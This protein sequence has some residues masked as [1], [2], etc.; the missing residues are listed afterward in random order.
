M[1]SLHFVLLSLV[2]APLCVF[3]T[4][5]PSTSKVIIAVNTEAGVGYFVDSV[6]S[7]L[8]DVQ[9]ESVKRFS[10]GLAGV[11]R[12]GKWG[13]IDTQGELVAP[14]IY[15]NVAFFSDGLALVKQNG[16]WG[17]VNTLGR[18]VVLCIYDWAGDFSDGLGVVRMSGK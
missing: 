17:A 6:G 3:S 14:C 11:R 2:L 4:D 8:F 10:E 12:N 7:P 1:K 16:K 9:F 18:M 15:D 5:T 13:F